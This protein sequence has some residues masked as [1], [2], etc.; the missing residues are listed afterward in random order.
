MNP[1]CGAAGAASPYRALAENPKVPGCFNALMKA[2]REAPALPLYPQEP[3]TRRAARNGREGLE[4]EVAPPNV[5]Q[6]RAVADYGD[7]GFGRS[8][9]WL[10][11]THNWFA[12]RFLETGGTLGVKT[13]GRCL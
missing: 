11:L 12:I 2:A 9:G 1:R 6:A 8:A 4:A 3:T 10:E 7:A 5:R 13:T